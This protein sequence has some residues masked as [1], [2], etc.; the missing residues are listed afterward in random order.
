[1][2]RFSKLCSRVILASQRL[3]GAAGDCYLG[4]ST[5]QGQGQAGWPRGCAEGS[6]SYTAVIRKCH[7]LK[8]FRM[9]QEI[10][11]V[12]LENVAVSINRKSSPY[13]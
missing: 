5:P 3:L 12:Y 6:S 8:G 13:P 2:G 9:A 10:L 1:M 11:M 4:A 7:L